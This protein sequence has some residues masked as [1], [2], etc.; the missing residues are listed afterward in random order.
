MDI[1]NTIYQNQLHSYNKTN[2]VYEFNQYQEQLNILINLFKL[3]KSNKK[4]KI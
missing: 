3:I 2:N 1:H 4:Y